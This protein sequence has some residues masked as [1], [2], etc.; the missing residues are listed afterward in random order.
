[1]EQLQ[2]LRNMSCHYVQGYLM[3]PPLDA[4]SAESYLVKAVKTGRLAPL[5]IPFP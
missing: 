4:I 3:S 1:M 2:E 5:E